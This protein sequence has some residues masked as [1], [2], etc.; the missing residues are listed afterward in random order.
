[1]N[2]LDKTRVRQ[3]AQRVFGSSP[4]FLAYAYGSR[5]D[6][7]PM[8]ESDLDIGYYLIGFPACEDLSIRDEMLLS[9]DLSAEIGLAVDLRNLGSAPL[10][11]RGRALAQGIRIYCLDDVARVNLE[12]DLLGRFHDYKQKFAQMHR[13]RLHR[14]A[15]QGLADG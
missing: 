13:T 15:Q 11:L 1:M 7:K 3:A 2:D 14:F 6:G 12:R 9:A 4:V 5:V 8:P 10:E